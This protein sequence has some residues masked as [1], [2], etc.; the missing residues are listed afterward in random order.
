[1]Q[2][3]PEGTSPMLPPVPNLDGKRIR[4]WYSP[5]ALAFLG[6]SVWELYVRR[7]YF[8]PPGRITQYYENVTSQVRAE[9][10]E[11]HYELLLAGSF[12]T[13]EEREVLAWGC[14]AKVTVPPRFKNNG[15]AKLTYKHATA[16]EVLAG[17]LYLTKPQRLHQMMIYLGLGAEIPSE[18]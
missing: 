11:T 7:H 6:D 12:T 2:E 3:F 9:T 17:Y 1:M 18:V 8:Y 13:E 15:K 14:N 5:T 16:M 10:Q 4:A